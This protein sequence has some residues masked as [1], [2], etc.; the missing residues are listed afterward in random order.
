MRRYAC[1]DV[2]CRRM[3]GVIQTRFVDLHE[4]G[5][6]LTHCENLHGTHASTETHVAKKTQRNARISKSDKSLGHGAVAV[7]VPGNGIG[8]STAHEAGIIRS[9]SLRRQ[10]GATSLA[11]PPCRRPAWVHNM[12]STPS[13]P[14]S[15][16]ARRISIIVLTDNRADD[17]IVTLERLLVLPDNPLVL[18]ADN[19]SDDNT[20]ALV[21]GRYPTVCVCSARAISV[22]PVATAPMRRSREQRT[23]FSAMKG[24]TVG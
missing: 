22:R 5:I 15:P 18:V 12:H 24:V 20:V 3:P 7:P 8:T 21:R 16:S 1:D 6:R 4:H 11:F 19:A 9:R 13:A 10:N 23:F 2:P 14:S 17:V